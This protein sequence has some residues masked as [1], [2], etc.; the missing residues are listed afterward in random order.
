MGHFVYIYRD[1]SGKARYVGYG[2]NS[3][4]ALS[5]RTKT[6]N[7]KLEQLLAN[8]NLSLE[9]AGPFESKTVGIAAETALISALKPDANSALAPGPKKYRFRPVGV[10]DEFVNRILAPPLSLQDLQK[11]LAKHQS[12]QFLCVKITDKA[13]EDGERLGYD[14]ANPPKDEIVVDRIIQYWLLAQKRKPWIEDATRSPTILLAVYGTP[15]SQFIVAAAAI[16]RNG[17]IKVSDREVPLAKPRNL[18]VAALRGRRIER[19]AGLKFN[20]DGVKLFL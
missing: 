15:G 2:E 4:R 20:L 13:F 8:Q 9:I 3:A 6:H 7:A 19:E 18:D 5:H 12:S 11:V 10:R 1:K 17:W 14:P 16:D